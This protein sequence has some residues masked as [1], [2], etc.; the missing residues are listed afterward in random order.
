MIDE[1]TARMIAA[2]IPG[3]PD[4]TLDFGEYY[5]LQQNTGRGRVIRVFALDCYP[6][7]DGTRY[8]CYTMRGGQLVHVDDGWGGDPYHGIYM[9][10]LYD[11]KED[12]KNQTHSW[13]EG[14]EKLRE[15]QKVEAIP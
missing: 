11:N 1:H 5:F 8:G 6:H 12:C 15:I 3:E 4:P 13:Y 9:S 14:W 10:Q 2:Y 7:R